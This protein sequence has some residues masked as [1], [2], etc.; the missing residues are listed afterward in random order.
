MKNHKFVPDDEFVDDDDGV[1]VVVVVCYYNL[2]VVA[3]DEID[4]FEI[5]MMLDR[6]VNRQLYFVYLHLKNYYLMLGLVNDL[7]SVAVEIVAAVDIDVLVVV[8]VVAVVN[9]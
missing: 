3:F 6:A 2:V 7:N 4:Y 8:V 1:V 9:Y 5:G